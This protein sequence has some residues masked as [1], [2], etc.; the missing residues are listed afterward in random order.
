MP[1]PVPD[2]SPEADPLRPGGQ[3]GDR[4]RRCGV[5]GRCG[6]TFARRLR[7]ALAGAYP[8]LTFSAGIA[9]VQAGRPVADTLEAADAAMYA[10]KAAGHDQVWVADPAQGGR[11]RVVADFGLAEQLPGLALSG[12]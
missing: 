3:S 6:T 12:A 4:S 9:G 11:L 5:A 2:R 8:G 10:A 7:G 1:D